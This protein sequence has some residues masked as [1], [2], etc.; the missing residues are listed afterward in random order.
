M[1]LSNTKIESFPYPSFIG[2]CK[3][4]VLRLD[5]IDPEVSGNKYFKLKYA[6]EAFNDS[7]HRKVATFGGAYSNHILAT[8]KYCYMQSIPCIGIIRGDGYDSNNTTLSR[9]QELGM[10][11]VFVDREEYR[12]RDDRDYQKAIRDKYDAYVIPEGGKSYLGIIGSMEISNLFPKKYNRIFCASGTG[13]TAAGLM[14]S[15]KKSTVHAVSALK[16]DFMKEDILGCLNQVLN[17]SEESSALL[18]NH[19]IH[20]DYHFGGYAKYDDLLVEFIHQ[21]YH[22]SGLRLDPIYT[23]K[24]F[25]AMINHIKSTDISDSYLFVHSGGLQGVKGY[26]SRYGITLF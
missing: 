21:V 24:A 11:L 6:I 10:E 26:E 12:L 19:V 25:F 20:H 13:S 4:D 9:A 1:D 17:S 22:T 7:Q 3:V 8:A 15:N 16:G 2:D 14:L 5:L 18:N 23:S